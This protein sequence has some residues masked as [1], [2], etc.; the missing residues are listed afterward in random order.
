MDF[1]KVYLLNEAFSRGAL[2]ADTA[3]TLPDLGWP[4]ASGEV[5]PERPLVFKQNMGAKPKD[6]VG[7]GDVGID[8]LSSRTI[9]VLKENGFSGWNSYP[10]KLLNKK[11]RLI[12]GYHGFAVT[13]Q[14]GSVDNSKSQRVLKL[15]PKHPEGQ[16]PV[17]IGLYFDPSTWDGTDIFRPNGTVHTFV[18][19]KVKE[20]FEQAKIT[21]VRFKKLTEIER[22]RAEMEP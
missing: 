11:G 18:V 20:A 21:N 14:C 12:P 10:V 15:I 19:E 9:G 17:W 4:I 3:L 8:L 13:G 2:R 7:T 6:F 22:L 16:M 1:G 5:I